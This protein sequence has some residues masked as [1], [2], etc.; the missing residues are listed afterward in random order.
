MINAGALSRCQAQ[1]PLHSVYGSAIP[2]GVHLTLPSRAGFSRTVD[3][4]PMRRIPFCLANHS[5]SKRTH[6][7]NTIG[8][9][10]SLSCIAPQF[11]ITT[12]VYLMRYIM[13][14]N[15]HFTLFRLSSCLFLAT[16]LDTNLCHS[17]FVRFF[18]SFV[19]VLSRYVFHADY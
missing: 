6:L 13:R 19:S 11:Y 12:L 18:L 3:A 2:C 1:P 5:S 14:T 9:L 17:P 10:T 4:T 7:M 15:I 16:I 8:H